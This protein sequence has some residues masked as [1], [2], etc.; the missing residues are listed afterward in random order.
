MASFD[1]RNNF[2]M[3]HSYKLEYGCLIIK[4]WL[5]MLQS[6]ISDENNNNVTAYHSIH[7]TYQSAYLDRSSL[8]SWDVVSST[9]EKDTC[10][11]PFLNPIPQNS[12]QGSPTFPFFDPFLVTW[13]LLTDCKDSGLLDG[14]KISTV[15]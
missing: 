13:L 4:Q 7:E 11:N 12:S 2:F 9:E 10:A 3:G 5:D 8:S 15:L 14:S 6:Q 1:E